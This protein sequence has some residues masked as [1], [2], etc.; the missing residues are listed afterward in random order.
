[1]IV[2]TKE[3]A[4]FVQTLRETEVGEFIKRPLSGLIKNLPGVCKALLTEQE[5]D[6]WII[7]LMWNGIK[8]RDYSIELHGGKTILEEL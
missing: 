2:G 5:G 4:S 3:A 8:V 6:Y 7:R 1:M